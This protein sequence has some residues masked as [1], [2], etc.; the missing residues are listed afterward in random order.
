VDFETTGFEPHTNDPIQV[1]CVL[2]G[3]APQFMELLAFCAPI[4]C[5][6]PENASASAMAIHGFTTDAL[7]VAMPQKVVFR[8]LRDTIRIRGQVMAAAHNAEFDMRFL[9][10]AEKEH[11][12]YIDRPPFP[13]FCTMQFARVHL[14]ARDLTND[15]K[16][17][18]VA[19]HYGITFNAHD[20]LGDVRAT[21]EIIRRFYAEAPDLF[22]RA[23]NGDLLNGLIRDACDAGATHLAED[24]TRA[25]GGR[26]F[27]SPQM[28]AKLVGAA[29]RDR[30][31][32]R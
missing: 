3:P 29:G 12:F 19:A 8:I 18:T 10:A 26:G 15:A 13:P 32:A 20:A 25:I 14:Q 4:K 22:Q 5:A 17:A 30:V 21:A 16:L 27:L 11:G 1:A 7:E 6:R 2:L 31:V 23:M 28:I 24:A 9:A